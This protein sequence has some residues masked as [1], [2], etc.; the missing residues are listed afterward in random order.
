MGAG[1][2]VEFQG[3]SRWR[4]DTMAKKN[5]SRNTGDFSF[6][7][8]AWSYWRKK[9]ISKLSTMQ[10]LN[11]PMGDGGIG[12]MVF[13]ARCENDTGLGKN[14]PSP[15]LCQNP[16]PHPRLGIFFTPHPQKRHIL[17]KICFKNAKIS[18][19]PKNFP[20]MGSFYAKS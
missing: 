8:G 4:N 3:S 10:L 12:G 17:E 7:S 14:L 11:P 5:C 1:H 6:L 20:K 15:T 18:W 2:T 16:N 9:Y 19:K 13:L